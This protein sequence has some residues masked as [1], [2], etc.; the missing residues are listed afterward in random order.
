M[1]NQHPRKKSARTSSTILARMLKVPE[2]TSAFELASGL[3]AYTSICRRVLAC[4]RNNKDKLIVWVGFHTGVESSV[5]TRSNGWVSIA[6]MVPLEALH[7][8]T[9]QLMTKMR[10]TIYSEL[11]FNLTNCE[12]NTL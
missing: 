1:P 5:V 3:K 10:L 6:A 9:H 8:E 11:R 12:T 7:V 2:G 4:G